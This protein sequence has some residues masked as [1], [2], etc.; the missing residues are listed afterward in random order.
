[1]RVSYAGS[2]SEKRV[3]TLGDFWTA[4]RLLYDDIATLG[5]E[6]DADSVGKDV[7]TSENAGTTGVAELDVLVCPTEL[8]ERDTSP[9]GLETESAR[10]G[11]NTVHL[12]QECQQMDAD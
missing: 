12:G 11:R 5:T 9:V 8:D 1:M 4:V 10:G 3:R 2:A 7:D 6:G